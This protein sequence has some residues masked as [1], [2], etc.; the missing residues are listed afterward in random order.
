MGRM[1]ETLPEYD[2][3]YDCGKCAQ[4]QAALVTLNQSYDELR[5]AYNALKRGDG[6]A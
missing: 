2:Y 1:K 3:D 5:R 6:E 4:L